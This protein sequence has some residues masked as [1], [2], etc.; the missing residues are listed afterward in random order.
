MTSLTVRNFACRCWI[1]GNW[2]QLAD[3]VVTRYSTVPAINIQLGKHRCCLQAKNIGKVQ[4]AYQTVQHGTLDQSTLHRL[5]T[6]A[7][8]TAGPRSFL[9]DRNYSVLLV[10]QLQQQQLKRQQ[11]K[12]SVDTMS[13]SLPHNSEQSTFTMYFKQ[14]A[15]TR[16]TPQE[17]GD[18]PVPMP[19]LTRPARMGRENTSQH[20]ACIKSQWH[21]KTADEKHSSELNSRLTPHDLLDV[22]RPSSTNAAERTKRVVTCM[23]T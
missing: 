22:E 14:T 6:A 7:C 15:R 3:T 12:E 9:P 23:R 5:Y 10:S 18:L 13:G 20:K 17:A 2:S 19:I 1:R 21:T 8:A 11:G 16:H 4:V